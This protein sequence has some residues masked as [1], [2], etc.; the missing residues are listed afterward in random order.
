MRRSATV[1]A[2]GAVAVLASQAGAAPKPQIT[3]AKG[4][5]PVAAGDIVSATLSTVQK[6]LR[7][8]L[9]IDLVLA[10]AP[11]T[12]TPYSYAVGFTVGACNFRAIHYGHP[13]DGV[14][15]K[16]GVGC[17][18]GGTSLPEGSYKIKGSTITF[19][20]P[21]T[22][23]LKRGAKATKLVADTQPSG[24]VSGGAVAALGDAA[25]GKDWVLGS[26]RPKKK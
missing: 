21:M 2:L 11:S 8:Q 17:S 13:A 1:A 23:A 4:D 24:A 16:S 18:G 12:S 3:D 9:Q 5:Y 26:D 6:G 7:E 20:V 10:A 14:F 22:G 25:T 15:S 19:T